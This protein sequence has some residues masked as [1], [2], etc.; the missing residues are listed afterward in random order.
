MTRKMAATMA[1][2]GVVA[3]LLVAV[4]AT[5]ASAGPLICDPGSTAVRWDYTKKPWKITHETSKENYSGGELRRT[6]TVERI[7]RLQARAELHTGVEVESGLAT[8]IF[9]SL[10][11][12]LDLTLAGEGEWTKKASEKVE[13]RMKKQGRYVFYAGRRQAS[14]YW[15]VYRCDG[16]TKWV[17]GKYGFA[18]SFSLNTEGAVWCKARPSRKSLAYV[19]KK[20]YC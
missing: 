12:K 6:V 5:T 2:A 14:G 10:K 9:A 13:W 3:S 20:H 4:P 17:A 11:G 19:V 16:G 18:K 1:G 8:K 15:Q 7:R